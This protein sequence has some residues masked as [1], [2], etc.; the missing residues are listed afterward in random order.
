VKFVSTGGSIDGHDELTYPTLVKMVEASPLREQLHAGGLDRAGRGQELFPG[1]RPS[2]STS[3]RIPIRGDVRQPHQAHG[4][5][6]S[7]G[8]R[9]LST[10][11]CELNRGAFPRGP[12]VAFPQGD[13]VAL[14]Q[15]ILELASD[16]DRLAET[17]ERLKE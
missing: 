16:P 14:G 9:S 5:G 10:D 4:L 12:A 1:V 6:R 8:C 3:T 15:K 2:A 11:L 7:R 13:A 17:G